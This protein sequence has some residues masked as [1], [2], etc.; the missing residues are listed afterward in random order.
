MKMLCK[1]TFFLSV[2]SVNFK[3][4]GGEFFNDIIGWKGFQINK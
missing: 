1:L 4:I 2:Y 3:D